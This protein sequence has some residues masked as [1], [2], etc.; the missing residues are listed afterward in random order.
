MLALSTIAKIWKEP[1]CPLTEEQI[2]KIW[3]IDTMAYYSVIKKNKNLPFAVNDMNG[4][5][6]YYAK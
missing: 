4:A 2:K 3:Y 5:K 6:V 1:K